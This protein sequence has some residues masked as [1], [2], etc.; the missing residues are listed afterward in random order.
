MSRI[1]RFS[2]GPVQGFVA[3]SRR[4]RDLWAGSFLLSWLT[5][6]AMKIVLERSGKILVPIVHNDAGELADA[7]LKAIKGVPDH[8]SPF[9]GSLPNQFTAEISPTFHPS[10]CETAIREQWQRLADAVWK[11]FL[12]PVASTGRDTEERWKQQIADFWEI[13]WI[14]GEADSL[15]AS[16]DWLQRR[17]N[18][19]TVRQSEEEYGTDQCTVMGDW[20]E[21]SGYPRSVNRTKQDDFWEA[22]RTHVA[23]KARNSRDPENDPNP[24]VLNLRDD[25]RLCAIA[26]VKR[27]FPK[28][29]KAELNRVIGWVP[30][31]NPTSIGNWPSTAHMAA[32]RWIRAAYDNAPGDCENYVSRIDK[33]IDEDVRKDPGMYGETMTGL[34]CLAAL[35]ASGAHSLSARFANLDGQYFFKADL[36]NP[37]AT[38]FVPDPN[39]PGDAAKDPKTGLPKDDRARTDA[40][41]ALKALHEALDDKG[42]AQPSPFYAI[43]LMDGDKF[44]DLVRAHERDLAG[45]SRRI[46]LFLEAVKRNV[47]KHSGA[48]IYAGGDDVL[49]LLTFEDAIDCAIELRKAYREAFDSQPNATISASIVFAHY[50]L[51]LKAMLREA[52]RLLDK[53]A[54]HANGRDSLAIGVWQ[55]SGHTVEWASSWDA[56]K[57]MPVNTLVNLVRQ[58][59]NTE[60]VGFSSRFLYKIREQFAVLADESGRVP[61]NIEPEDILVAEYLRNRESDD[62][63]AQARQNVR[64]LLQVCRVN[65]RPPIMEQTLKPDGALL[66]RFLANNGDWK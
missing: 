53:V 55:G 20:P 39:G 43:L 54:K 52:H 62:D 7:L 10:E 46:A 29:G 42:I 9:I 6:H 38:R 35:K 36:A 44:G 4:T 33:L 40:Q 66:V 64:Q 21:L 27:L 3:Q 32:A 11:M 60:E 37:R 15:S 26:F 5:G 34:E 25:E 59:A 65:K 14:T 61:A 19:R 2:L 47:P 13:A 23:Q 56:D 63:E 28:L 12:E 58:F 49:A 31:R 22:V 8:D 16:N 41:K 50:H 45:L 1:L 30:G 24:G 57:A 48:L 18:W 17:K 51:P